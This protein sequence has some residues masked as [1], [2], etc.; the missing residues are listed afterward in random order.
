MRPSSLRVIGAEKLRPPSVE[1]AKRTLPVNLFG[2]DW[3]QLSSTVPSC[4]TAILG[5]FSAL[6]AISSGADETATGREKRCPPSS[7]R[8]TQSCWFSTLASHTR[9]L[10]SSVAPTARVGLAA[11]GFASW[12]CSI[13]AA[14]WYASVAA[15][16]NAKLN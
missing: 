1:R 10:L 2:S 15:S 13:A 8:E 5:R 11:C 9:P 6:A 16:S 4:A 7:D 12:R 14:G 3:L